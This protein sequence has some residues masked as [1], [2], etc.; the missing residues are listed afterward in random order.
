VRNKTPPTQPRRRGKDLARLRK[1]RTVRRSHELHD[2]KLMRWPK[3]FPNVGK[4][5]AG[6]SITTKKRKNPATVLPRQGVAPKRWGREKAIKPTS[7]E[8]RDSGLADVRRL[9]N[10]YGQETKKPRGSNEHRGGLS[11][12]TSSRVI[13]KVQCDS[14][15][16]SYKAFFAIARES[17]RASSYRSL[18]VVGAVLTPAFSGKNA[19]L[20]TSSDLLRRELKQAAQFLSGTSVAAADAHRRTRELTQRAPS[21][22]AG[23]SCGPLRNEHRYERSSGPSA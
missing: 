7:S 12:P 13:H 8:E 20:F 3:L 19:H 2:Q 21:A 10:H 5:V 17:A 11:G 22:M 14:E 18:I 16:S 9:V 23:L 15:F 1:H 6:K 4:L